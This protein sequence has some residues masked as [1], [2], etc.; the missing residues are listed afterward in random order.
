MGHLRIVVLRG[1]V[2]LDGERVAAGNKCLIATCPRANQASQMWFHCG[3]PLAH[4]V[5]LVSTHRRGGGASFSNPR[6]STGVVFVSPYN[7]V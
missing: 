3:A 1:P 7:C 5:R 6:L 4:E 2:V